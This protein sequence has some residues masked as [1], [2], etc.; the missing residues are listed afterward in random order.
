MFQSMVR[1][2]VAEHVLLNARPGHARAYRTCLPSRAAVL[3]TI[4][5]AATITPAAPPK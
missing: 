2:Q 5:A 1:Q 3:K 4:A